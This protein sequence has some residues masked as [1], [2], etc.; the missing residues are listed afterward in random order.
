MVWSIQSGVGAV[1]FDIHG[2]SGMVLGS[3]VVD[4]GARASSGSLDNG[5]EAASAEP[6]ASSEISREGERNLAAGRSCENDE[7]NCMAC[8]RVD[9]LK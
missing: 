5:P 1:L 3:Y 8:G 4:K 6:T 9:G 7:K 2:A